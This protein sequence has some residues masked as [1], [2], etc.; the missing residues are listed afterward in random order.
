[1]IGQL[2][3]NFPASVYNQIPKGTFNYGAGGVNAWRSICGGPNGGSALLAQLGAPTAVKD[4]FNAWYERNMF[5]SNA[6]YDDYASGTWTLTVTAPLSGAPQAKPGGLLCHQ[7]HGKWLKAAGG[8]DGAWVKKFASTTAAGGD[9]CSKLV[10]DCVYKL[11]TL[12]NDWKAGTLPT[13]ALDPSATTAGCMV[14]GCHVAPD[15]AVEVAG[16]MKCT[17]SCHK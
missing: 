11:C 14:A 15:A 4:E 3:A 1:V 13:G 8:E 16:K 7:S 12:I 6:A 9:R 17:D 5:P 2:A 10:Y